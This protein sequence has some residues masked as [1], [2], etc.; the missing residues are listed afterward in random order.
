VI[1]PDDGLVKYSEV[2]NPYVFKSTSFLRLGDNSGDS[3]I[4]LDIYDNSVVVFCKQNPWL[5]YMP[6]STDTEW[7]VMRVRA[8]YGSQSPLG[9]FKFENK[10][11]YP[12]IQNS[13]LVGFAAIAGQ[14]V[15]PT[16]SILTTTALGSDLIS[17]KVE[18]DVIDIQEGN[19]L[20][21][22]VSYVFQ[23]KAYIAAQKA[24]G[25]TENN[26]IYVF[27]FS[28]GNL[29]NYQ[30]YTWVPWSGIN[31][32]AFTEYNGALYGG[33]SKADGYVQQLN[34]TTYNDNGSAIDSYIWTKEF[35]GRPGEEN[36]FK[37][38]R[39]ATVFYGRPGSYYMNMTTRV[40]SDSGSGYTDQISI[41]PGGSNW[42]TLVW[43]TDNWDPGQEDGEIKKSLGTFRGKRIQ[44]KFSNQ[45][46]VNQKF[47]IYGLNFLYNNKG[48]R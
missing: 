9:S 37:D 22:I 43:G 14:T 26:R 42:G 7:V 29:A 18:P 10:V 3:P 16:A 34:T 8:N 20:S 24:A 31:V 15:T 32:K 19:A 47:K 28:I 30:K 2:G 40:D 6:S 13:R 12:A 21:N 39:F 4:G 36:L 23:N 35:S 46:T 44:F 11:A 48:L 41:S 33:S 5:I 1:D 38:F 27:D 45:N 25:S 17:Q